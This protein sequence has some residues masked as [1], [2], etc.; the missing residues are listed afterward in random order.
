[1]PYAFSHIF[2]PHRFL[3]TNRE[4]I[5]PEYLMT[6]TAGEPDIRP[7]SNGL[8]KHAEKSL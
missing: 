4:K 5:F 1:M 2:P 7:L 8:T 6:G 3:E